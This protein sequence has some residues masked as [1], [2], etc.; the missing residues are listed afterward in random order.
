[1]SIET[2]PA[3]YALLGMAILL[4][5]IIAGCVSGPSGAPQT[6]AATTAIPPAP[7][8]SAP[9]AAETTPVPT[10]TA[11]VP[12]TTQ[13][14]APVAPNQTPTPPPTTAI[15]I[16]N[17]TLNPNNVTIS[18]GTMVVWTNLDIYPHQLVSMASPTVGPGQVFLSPVLQKNDTFSFTFNATGVYQYN[19]VDYPNMLGTIIVKG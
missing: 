18:V 7:V 16:R 6:P 9:T 1:M 14:A 3:R 4:A 19:A 2:T 10:G 5:V 17:Y 12:P 8:S 15:S 13:A 11:P